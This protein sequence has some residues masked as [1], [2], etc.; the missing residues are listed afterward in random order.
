MR[1]HLLVPGKVI[2]V[3]T[4]VLVAA[5]LG[6]GG[7]SRRVL[8]GCLTRKFRP[9]MGTALFLEYES[10]MR[11]DAL[12]RQCVL[13]ASERDQLLDAFLKVCEWIRIYYLWRPNLRD[14]ADNHVVELAVAAAAEVIVT[15]NVKD[16]RRAE[17]KFPGL[18]ILKPEQLTEEE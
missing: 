11:R 14:E 12:F 10:V 13:S 8:R 4:D 17:L 18:R 5:L 9:V 7:A 2:V 6:A 1:Y 15:R 3:D 16:F